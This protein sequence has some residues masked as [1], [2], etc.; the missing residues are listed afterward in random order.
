[1]PTLDEGLADWF[2]LHPA[3]DAV[4]KLPDLSPKASGFV[5][6]LWPMGMAYHS[7]LKPR[8]LIELENAGL[9]AGSETFLIRDGLIPLLWF[10]RKWPEPREFQGKI[11]I[12]EQ[13]APYVPP[14]WRERVLFYRL[15][16][17]P[18][19]PSLKSTRAPKSAKRRI[20]LVGLVMPGYCSL[21]SLKKK[22][23]PLKK[24]RAEVVAFLPVRFGQSTVPR[25]A[26]HFNSFRRF[27]GPFLM[28]SASTGEPSTRCRAGPGQ[29]FSISA[30]G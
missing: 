2:Q 23:A 27:A 15:T 29:R 24:T 30:T 21:E 5:N 4:W 20:L 11:L 26:F 18:R 28:S 1:V 12:G 7:P 9:P 8:F 19:A 22:L 10:W 17:G 13:F 16:A 25:L 3:R 14:A 6:N